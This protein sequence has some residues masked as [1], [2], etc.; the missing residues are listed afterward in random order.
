MSIRYA[1]RSRPATMVSTWLNS[2]A[3]GTVP[4]GAGYACG[5]WASAR[6]AIVDKY[7]WPANTRST[8]ASLP[9]S[10]YT[11][12][13]LSDAGV[14]GYQAGLRITGSPDDDVFKLVFSTDTWSTL[15]NILGT[16]RRHAGGFSN[17][18]T[19]AYICGGES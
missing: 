5:G 19:A 18:G 4:T 1:A 7:F 15:S 6:T 10:T 9:A 16:A 3:S 17:D 2:L 13:G 12:V 8:S 14:A 11:N